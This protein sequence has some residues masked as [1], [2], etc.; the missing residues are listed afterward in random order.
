VT[1]NLG[2]TVHL[3][4]VADENGQTFRAEN[5][6]PGASDRLEPQ[7]LANMHAE[8]RKIVDGQRLETPAEITSRYYAVGFFASRVRYWG[9]RSA[10]QWQSSREEEVFQA[11]RAA[12]LENIKAML[13]PR[14]YIA[15]TEQ[16]PT[17]D[18][19]V[20]KMQDEGSL[21]IVIGFY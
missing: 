1:N 5:I 20:T 3:L 18:L 11:L 16:P 12:G 17:V 6:A 4:L 7:D 8:L 9:N 14:T 15:V 19:G 10:A 2:A 13:Q 21:F